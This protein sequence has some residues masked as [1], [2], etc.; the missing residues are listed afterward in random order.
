MNADLKRIRTEAETDLLEAFANAEDQLPGRA[1]THAARRARMALFEREGLPHRRIEQW[2]YTD[3]RTLVRQLAP[4]A[5]QTANASAPAPAVEGAVQIVLVDGFI[6]HHDAVPAGVELRSLRTALEEGAVELEG[7]STAD[8]AIDA[9]NSAF[10]AD[11]VIVSI[12]PGASISTPLEIVFLKSPS[13]SMSHSRA[14]I[15][16]GE[17]AQ[18]TIIERHVGGAGEAVQSTIVTRYAVAEGAS[19]DVL[20]VQDDGAEAVH[21][22]ETAIDIAGDTAVRLMHLGTGAKIARVETRATF[23]GEGS[24]FDVC[25]VTMAARR[26]HLDHTLYVDHLVPGCEST[27]T[28]R[29]VIDDAAKGIFQGKIVVAQDAQKTDAQMASDALLLSETADMVAKP[30]L[31][32]FADDVSCAHGATCGELDDDLMFYLLA[33][34]IPHPQARKLLLHAFLSEALETFD[35]HAFEDV[36]LAAI[37]AWLT[38]H[39][40][41]DEA[42]SAS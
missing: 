21:L 11:G 41:A 7:P 31:E 3:L 42:A 40:N 10:V 23:R 32:I 38:D 26:Q 33:R 37:E 30:E 27:E 1:E 25:G 6:M 8:R 29:S 4:L 24:R 17:G 22:G 19:L 9:L 13:A 18:A 20:R 39:A 5:A 14:H 2:K 28:F 12:A 35:S 16:V 36:A 15:I 34:G